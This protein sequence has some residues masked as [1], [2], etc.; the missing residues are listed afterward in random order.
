MKSEMASPCEWIEDAAIDQ[1]LLMSVTMVSH[2]S[3][4]DGIEFLEVNGYKYTMLGS[5]VGIEIRD[6]PDLKGCFHS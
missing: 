1:H 4:D 3:Q 2:Q 5:K 6:S